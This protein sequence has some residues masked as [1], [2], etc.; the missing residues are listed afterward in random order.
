MTAAQR[1]LIV[2]DNAANLKVARLTLECEG[3]EVR[4]AADADE[5]VSVIA[6]FA[7][8]LVLMDIQ[9]PGIDGLELTRRLKADPA[10]AGLAIVAVT[11]YAMHTDQERAFAAGCDGY[12][13]KPYDPMRLPAQVAGYLA[14]QQ[15]R[16]VPVALP[17]L[18]GPHPS[19]SAAREQRVLVVEN[20]PTTRRLFRV[21]LEGAG[22]VVS[23]ASDAR[24]ALAAVSSARPALV[25]MD[26]M[27]PDQSGTDFSRT[28][29]ARL[30]PSVPILCVSGFL[31]LEGGESPDGSF[32][33]VLRKPVDP[34]QLVDVVR[35]YLGEHV[36]GDALQG[37]GRRLLVVDDDPPQRRLAQAWFTTLGFEVS[38][39]DNGKSALAVAR[40]LRPV[41]IASDVLMP[42]MDGFELCHAVRHDPVLSG[43]PVVL[44]SSAYVESADRTLAA[45]MGA[46][47]L[48]NKSDGLR[49]V[50]SALA[51][52]LESPPT[53]LRGDS[54]EPLHEEHARVARRELARQVQRNDRLQQRCALQEAQLAVLA[55]TA[56]ALA[57]NQPLDEVLDEVLAT[58]LDMAGISTGAMY[59]TVGD[60]LELR[61]H[62][63]FRASQLS[64]L[65]DV[66]DCAA[67]LRA[68]AA[69]GKVVQL[70][71]AELPD[72]AYGR[73]VRGL[74]V[75]S[76]LVVPMTWGTSIHG[77]MLLGSRGAEFSGES[78]IAFARI[79][80]AQ[81]GQ[82][83]GLAGSFERLTT[84][85]KR[86]RAVAEH[87]SEAISILGIDGTIREINPRFCALLGRPAP[88]LLGS[89]I[90]DLV[91]PLHELAR[92]AGGPG[93]PTS[94]DVESADG[95][96]R[97]VEFSCSELELSGERVVL[98][99]GRDVTEQM[100][101]QAQLMASDRMASI[102]TL[103]AGVAHEIN[104]PLAAVLAT[105]EFAKWDLAKLE[106]EPSKPAPLQRLRD[107]L[108][109]A[110]CAADRVRQI[111]KDLKI[112]SR[113]EDA[114]SGPVD[115][116]A[117]LE[118][119]LRMAW[120]EI[121]H[122]ARL[123]REYDVVPAAHGDESRLG[124][125][126]L[127]LVMNAAQ[128][129]PE[130]RAN[131]HT[132][133]V[134]LESDAE[135]R[136]VASVRDTGPGI[137]P[138]TLRR[139][140]TPFFTTKPKGVGTGLGLVICQRIVTSLGGEISVESEPGVGTV[141]R[142]ALLPAREAVQAPVEAPPVQSAA[143]R[144]KV[145]LVDDDPMIGSFV[146]RKLH[147]EHDVRVFHSASEALECIAA[148]EAFD[149]ILCD[150]M[151]PIISGVD[152]YERLRELRAEHAAR[153]IFLTGGAFTVRAREFLERVGN[154]RLEK[155]FNL[156]SLRAVVNERI[157]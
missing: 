7:P 77:L 147:E 70:P 44:S 59:T 149:V 2:D 29:R 40:E 141:F 76:L 5:A 134:K 91:A 124:Q 108:A 110:E 104:N 79:L 113:S 143:R 27:L 111:V 56:E 42:E 122:R 133:T 52:A 71:S 136:V 43:T 123:V 101:A 85:E 38:T 116:K 88:A 1:I 3:F 132:I 129:L 8:R 115:T 63:G 118:S 13:S 93:A 131:E 137:P 9:L 95:S 121:R 75:T 22:Y 60:R 67:E 10:T 140:F 34:G 51:A 144:G 64:S 54:S 138:E 28:M 130:G 82:A 119:T 53:A 150:M 69:R 84:S 117:V 21:T 153:V 142:V 37:R 19:A 11:A 26:L 139:L 31:S 25:L 12:I 83:L 96:R 125:V 107:T 23:E 49:A 146:A 55:G 62:V 17:V 36:R 41:A 46:R 47:A 58:C 32:D 65:V 135:G 148:G 90:S 89:S 103:A 74:D 99:I 72:E 16:G 92:A 68:L 48:V 33:H 15:A 98:A 81:M 105:I 61:H 128:A 127:N 126:F 145:L 45:R 100:R 39:A 94:V 66:F 109:D 6:E 4:V 106:V 14:Q 102:G 30:G 18:A 120:N 78:A 87:A 50:A 156:D 73:L 114:L 24:G 157:L 152:F 151:M 20:N 86:Y 154:L 57:T 155:P 97:V 112:F 80:G 35:A